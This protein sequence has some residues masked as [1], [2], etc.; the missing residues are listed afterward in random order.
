MF[1]F[2]YDLPPILRAG[3][4]LLLIG[5]AAL[6]YFATAGTR[7]AYGMGLVGL[8]LL[9]FSSAGSNNSGYKF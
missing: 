2:W 6:T 9:L 4:G 5:I 7:I 1:D 8:V 3:F